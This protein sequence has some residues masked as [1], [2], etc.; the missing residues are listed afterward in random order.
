MK[1]FIILIA[2]LGLLVHGLP[3]LSSHAYRIAATVVLMVIGWL[4]TESAPL[5]ILPVPTAIYITATLI[6][7]PEG[8][9]HG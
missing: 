3:R 6:I 5:W 7:Q 9:H 2:L 4:G 8:D 1:D